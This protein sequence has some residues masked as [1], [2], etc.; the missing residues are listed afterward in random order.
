MR[1]GLRL[2][3]LLMDVGFLMRAQGLWTDTTPSAWALASELPFCYDRMDFPEWLQFVFIPNLQALAES[4]SPWPA[5]CAVTPMAEYYFAGQD[6]AAGR[7]VGVLKCVDDLVTAQAC[8]TE[9]VV[10]IR[11]E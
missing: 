5:E 10:V 11:K 4:Q 3:E 2:Q 1:A 7:L 9:M 8:S 6:I